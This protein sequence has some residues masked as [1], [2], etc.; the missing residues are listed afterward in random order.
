[1]KPEIGILRY[2]VN[3]KGHIFIKNIVL[4]I[5]LHYF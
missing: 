1:M 3:Y 2:T 4:A 5:D